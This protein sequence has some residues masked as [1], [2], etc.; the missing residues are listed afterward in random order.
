MEDPVNAI[1]L[2]ENGRVADREAETKA[3]P[4]HWNDERDNDGQVLSGWKG[5]FNS[6]FCFSFYFFARETAV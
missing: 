6:I 2:C 3:Q 1:G 4:E 5:A